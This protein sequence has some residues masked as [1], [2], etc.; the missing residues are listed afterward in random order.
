MR[1][2]IEQNER[3]E[4]K[5]YISDKLKR[6]SKVLLLEAFYIQNIIYQTNWQYYKIFLLH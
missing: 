1:I 6:A 2:F 5:L 4:I 3:E